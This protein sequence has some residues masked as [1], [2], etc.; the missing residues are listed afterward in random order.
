MRAL[1]AM[2]A[3]EDGGKSGARA[4]SG[5]RRGG[6]VA[7][8]ARSARRAVLGS[9]QYEAMTTLAAGEPDGGGG[10]AA[11]GTGAGAI[12]GGAT[13]AGAMRSGWGGRSGRARLGGARREQS[14]GGEDR[15]SGQGLASCHGWAIT[16]SGACCRGFR[17]MCMYVRCIAV[18][19]ASIP[20]CGEIGKSTVSVPNASNLEANAHL[21]R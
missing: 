10:T 4:W 5:A 13:A 9:V 7:A 21:P 17:P 19:P 1:A 2:G 18:Q 14:G 15:L 3:G 11:K 20:H 12:R 6:C 8:R 16:T